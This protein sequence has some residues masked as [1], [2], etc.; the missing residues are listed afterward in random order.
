MLRHVV[1]V[2]CG[3]GGRA[4]YLTKKYGTYVMGI[5]VI[6]LQVQ[7]ATTLAVTQGL[8]DKVYVFIDSEIGTFL[9]NND[10]TI[11]PITF[12]TV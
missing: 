5:I 8:G 6:S 1:D 12:L 11:F 2:V 4:R 7:G 10:S 9:A 3:L